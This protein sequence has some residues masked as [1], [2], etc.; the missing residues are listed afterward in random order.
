MGNISSK[1]QNN[2]TSIS[3]NID[4]V[5]PSV[6]SE[7]FV[8][9]LITG[10]IGHILI[11]YEIPRDIIV[12]CSDFYGYCT[13]LSD[14]TAPTLSLQYGICMGHFSRYGIYIIFI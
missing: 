14:L 8:D 7:D 11:N 2:Q 10:Y 9:L 5:S 13:E 1:S 6:S 3:K 12:I 4:T